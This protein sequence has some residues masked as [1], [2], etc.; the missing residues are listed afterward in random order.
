VV[1]H[2]M[3]ST[4]WKKATRSSSTVLRKLHIPRPGALV[5]LDPV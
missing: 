2:S 3:V 1:H 4:N 5:V